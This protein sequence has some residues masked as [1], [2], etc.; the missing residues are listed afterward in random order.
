MKR[1]QKCKPA[2]E[3]LLQFISRRAEGI[4]FSYT[5]NRPDSR[6]QN[7]NQNNHATGNTT[8]NTASTSSAAASGISNRQNKRKCPDPLCRAPD[9]KH[10]LYQCPRIQSLELEDHALGVCKSC[11]RKQCEHGKCPISPCQVCNEP[12]NSWL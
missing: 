7:T 4:D 6:R 9:N 3:P 1:P 8:G 2:I 10:Q 12:H 5:G 11:L